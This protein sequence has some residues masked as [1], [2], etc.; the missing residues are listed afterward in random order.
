MHLN[1]SPCICSINCEMA[2]ITAW[3]HLRESAVTTFSESRLCDEASPFQVPV[4]V[5]F[6]TNWVPSPHPWARP[7]PDHVHKKPFWSP[8]LTV[9]LARWIPA[10]RHSTAAWTCSSYF[11]AC[12]GLLD[13]PCRRPDLLVHGPGRKPCAYSMSRE[14]LNGTVTRITV[15]GLVRAMDETN[16]YFLF[17]LKFYRQVVNI[18]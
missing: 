11:C 18:V 17:K 5:W 14:C 7:F 4:W 15:H 3:L 13:L 6:Q 8:T 9:I 2:A 12:P 16:L 1:T 10:G